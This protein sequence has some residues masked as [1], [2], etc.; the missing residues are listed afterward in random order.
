MQHNDPAAADEM[1]RYTNFP[2]TH[3]VRF[4]GSYFGVNSTGLYLLEGTTDHASPTPTA[5]AWS[6][7]TAMTDFGSPFIKTV[8]SAYFHGRLG[9]EATIQLHVGEDGPKTYEYET[10]RSDTAKNYRQVFGRGIKAR[11]YA[12]GAAGDDTLALDGI[13]FNTLNTTRRI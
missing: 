13:E 1:T 3:I 9:A 8:V 7:K 4:Q 12:L 5:I 2:F 11:Y 6:W 10:V